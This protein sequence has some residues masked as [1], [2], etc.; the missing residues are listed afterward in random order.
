MDAETRLCVEQELREAARRYCEV[1][2]AI[3]NQRPLLDAMEQRLARMRAQMD[4]KLNRS[5]Y[6]FARMAELERKLE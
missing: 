5:A 2:A 3:A 6:W 4:S 1:E